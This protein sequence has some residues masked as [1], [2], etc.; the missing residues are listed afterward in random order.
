VTNINFSGFLGIGAFRNLMN[1]PRVQN[2]PL[3]LETPTFEQPKDMWGKEIAMLQKLSAAVA[4]IPENSLAIESVIG[5]V[6][7][8]D[9]LVA[10]NRN[11]VEKFNGSKHKKAVTKR[12]GGKKHHDEGTDEDEDD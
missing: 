6:Q 2:I 10:I 8:D 1:D 4:E 7:T 12:Q 11:S 3:I 9:Q 5:D